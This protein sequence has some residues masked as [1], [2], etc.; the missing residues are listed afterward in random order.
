[1]KF[2]VM[3]EN[4]IKTEPWIGPWKEPWTRR[5]R[6]EDLDPKVIRTLVEKSREAARIFVTGDAA[7]SYLGDEAMSMLSSI[8]DVFYKNGLYSEPLFIE[9]KE[10]V[11]MLR[12]N[13]ES[14]WRYLRPET[15]IEL[16]QEEVDRLGLTRDMDPWKMGYP[17]F[18][19]SMIAAMKAA[20]GNDI[21]LVKAMMS[22][23]EDYYQGMYLAC[24][25]LF[26]KPGYMG[27]PIATHFAAPRAAAFLQQAIFLQ[28]NESE[29]KKCDEL[30]KEYKHIMALTN[31]EMRFILDVYGRLTKA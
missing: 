28:L 2:S 11:R 10:T 17:D 29:K 14:V 31:P 15:F 9:T 26:G 13:P 4:A 25:L 23:E 30:R 12:F 18:Y 27:V 5:G 19:Q 21:I 8:N 16:V 6:M 1:M 3:A 24:L 7:D 20:Y 22:D